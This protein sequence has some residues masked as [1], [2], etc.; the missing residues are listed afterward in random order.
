[1]AGTKKRHASFTVPRPTDEPVT[2]ELCYERNKGTKAKPRWVAETAEFTCSS[3]VP[4]GVIAEL[5]ARGGGIGAM[6][7]FLDAVLTED[8]VPRYKELVH[9]TNVQVP[10]ATIAEV[11]S[12]L[13]D[14]YGGKP[15]P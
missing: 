1:M 2:F 7:L 12:W 14:E 9:D 6:L 10:G 4:A 5:F 15:R 13:L 11:V 3:R 8:D